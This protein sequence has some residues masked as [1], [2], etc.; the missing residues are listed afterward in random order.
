MPLRTRLTSLWRNLVQRDGVERDLDDEI[1]SVL[2]LMVEEKTRAGM[3]LE[4]ARRLATLELG[5]VHTVKEQVH[6]VQAGVMLESLVLDTRYACR[7]LRRAPLFAAGVA[8]TVGVGLA[9]V[10]SVF[11]V[12]NAYVLRPFPVRDP[13]SLYEV[14]VDTT[15][16]RRRPFTWREYNELTGRSDIFSELFAGRTFRAVVD[17]K[18]FSGELVTGNYFSVLGVR[19]VIGRT[20][21]PEDAAA[22]GARAVAVLS[23]S[24]WVNRFGRD[25][26]VLGQHI[27]VMDR[28]FEIVGVAE[29]TF[30]GLGDVSP[31]LWL[32]L[33]MAGELWPD[34]DI[35]GAA[36]TRALHVFARVR[37][38]LTVTQVT[39]QLDAWARRSTSARP[40]NERAVLV[41]VEPRATRVALTPGVLTLFSALTCAFGLILL[42]ACANVANLLLA[43]GITRQ[44]E[45]GLKLAIGAGR[46]RLI[47]QLLLESVL[48]SLLASVIGGA[49]TYGIARLMPYVVLGTLP[50]EALKVMSGLIV[51]LD[52]DWRVYAFVIGAATL[53]AAAFGILPAL[54][55]TGGT[56]RD[57]LNGQFSDGMR[58]MRLRNSLVVAQVATC[59]L[60][61]V[62]ALG[63]LHGIREAARQDTG[64]D[65]ARVADARVPG[66]LSARIAQNLEAEPSIE[67]VAL[68]WRP[69]LYGPLR[70][71]VVVP[72]G[73]QH[74]VRVGFNLVSGEYFDVFG[75]RVTR[76]RTFTKDEAEAR[77]PVVIVSEM[78]A[79][80][81]WPS[82]DPLHQS[83]SLPGFQLPAG[84]LSPVHRSVRVIGVVSDVVSGLLAE[85]RDA[86]CVYFPIG[87][88]VAAD[89]SL[90][91]RSRTE[92]PAVRTSFERVVSA[93]GG[94][95][96][97]HLV[98]MEQVLAFQTWP[99][100]ASGSIASTLAMIALVMALSGCYGVVSYVISQRTREFGIRLALGA[101]A[102]RVVR[103]ALVSSTKLGVYGVGCGVLL[104]FVASKVLRAGLGPIPE[105]H[106]L[107]YLAGAAAV[108]AATV[109]AA[110][111]PCR[112]AGRVEPLT[113]L[114]R[115]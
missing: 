88:N 62:S 81:L 96:D 89:I 99:L 87:S 56:L 107:A 30:R 36:Q 108:L 112:R 84:R 45:I 48:L 7:G 111:G 16:T 11:A 34:L 71:L 1:L 14:S 13:F 41:R 25:R 59:T 106:V 90:L 15:V 95:V 80:R 70:P 23:Y 5:R 77:S 105:F 98:P 72:S 86:T 55:L 82:A 76:G 78:T 67:R 33:T 110:Y 19:S 43:R 93:A 97:R 6:D 61:F 114:R 35:F 46:G 31:N 60:L 74:E 53:S 49:L 63:L 83:L 109:A 22:P 17:G 9:V 52:P 64:L 101:T 66:A 50:E 102:S 79:L 47:R 113:S 68:A 24:T 94:D 10:C 40:E 100:R 51:P 32:P 44:R 42:I 12:F 115:D 58:P 38:D 8:L 29:S 37:P 28:A 91:L 26:G 69:P 39:M 57:A 21:V 18:P 20:F 3:S 2:E 27:R 103:E 92:A 4:Q 65:L 75:I 73:A 85:G 54:R 104:A